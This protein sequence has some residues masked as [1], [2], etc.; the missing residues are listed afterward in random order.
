MKHFHKYL[1]GCHFTI[2]TDYG[3]LT[4]LQNFKI[5]EEQLARWLKKLQDYQ[6]TIVHRPVANTIMLMPCPNCHASSAGETN[7]HISETSV[8]TISA[9]GLT[10]GYSAHEM[11]DLQV[12]DN[13]IGQI[14]L[15]KE[16]DQ[17]PSQDQAKRQSIEYRRL[18]QQW[19]QLYLKVCNGVLWWYCIQ[20]SED[21]SWLQLVVPYTL[22]EE[23]LKES[24]EDISECHLGQEKRLYHLKQQFCWPSH[25][26]DVCNWCLTCKDC[27]TRKTS[28]PTCQAS[29]GIFTAGYPTQVMQ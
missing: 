27:A 25:F 13:C 28:A 4:W 26:T 1:I 15:A 18:L 17:Q 8:T 7:T 21:N 22:R 14:L 9:T 5:S 20:P 2:Q 6:F 19:D 16:A 11:R 23:V 24:H 12:K 29:L 3:A 10:G